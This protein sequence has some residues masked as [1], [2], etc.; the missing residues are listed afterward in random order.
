M[1]KQ[2]KLIFYFVVLFLILLSSA[3]TAQIVYEP[4]NRDIYNFLLRISQRGVIEF[5]SQIK[6]VSRMYI[7]QK[8]NALS[9]KS[10]NLTS[11]E[12]KEL[13]FYK[14][15][16]GI[17]L[18]I[19]KKK[20]ESEA[21]LNSDYSFGK[22]KYG[23]FRLF[24]FS[25]D[26]FKI[27]LDPILGYEV[28]KTNSKN[29]NHIW[30][31]VSLFGYLS[32]NIGF[33]FDFRDNSESGAGIDS[34]KIFTPVTGVNPKLG[35]AYE[36]NEMN[37]S[38]SYNW[39][40]GEIS[41]GKGFFRWGYGKDGNIVLSTKAPSFPYFRLDIYPV[42][43]FR[44]NYIH[45]WLNSKVIDSSLSYKSL[46]S[47]PDFD[48]SIYRIKYFASHTIIL[49]PLKGLDFSLGESIIYS[50]RLE[51]AYLIP[52]MFFRLADHYLSNMNNNTGDNA[53]FFFGISSK[54]HIK[55][56][57]LYGSLFIDEIRTSEIF[58]SA[59][60]KNQFGF[61]I[62]GSIT[63]LPI[64]N[65]TANIEFTKIYPFVYR[66]FI[67]TQTYENQGYLMGH[68]IGDNADLIYA[69]LNYRFIRG[70]NLKLWY[71]YIRKGAEGTAEQM[72]TVPQPPFLFGLR[73]N[74]TH[75]G[76]DVKYEIIH[77]LFARAK[78]QYTKIEKE[79]E[80]LSFNTE[81]FSEFSFAVFYGL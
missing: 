9:Q 6:P 52:I 80:N 45:G 20:P 4:V 51:Y 62:G 37:V 66:H 5:N 1:L 79:Q 23:R 55:N 77:D 75:I 67:P 60:Q 13:E 10:I 54:N 14:E 29:R 69:S 53:Q 33:S 15:E 39:S 26:L 34:A 2:K 36:Y 41:V 18:S 11:L 19:L 40:W 16:F 73:T 17:E 57:H 7:A 58:N 70:L 8:L 65:F 74:Y 46:R 24:S 68:W 81:S 30:N 64:N 35:K 59:Q 31:G 76:L 25:N 78:F 50:D 22:D 28:G 43:W 27:N 12:R 56:T 48:R 61:T 32:D 63:D 42:N 38:L 49:T 47:S 21:A 44:F 3:S 72:Y 71:E